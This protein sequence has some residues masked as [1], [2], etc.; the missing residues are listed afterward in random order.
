MGSNYEYVLLVHGN[1]W[2]SASG[3]TCK[4]PRICQQLIFASII[5][6]NTWKSNHL[7]SLSTDEARE[8]KQGV[9]V[10]CLAGISRSVT[11]TVA[12]LMHALQMELEPAY[13]LVKECKPNI[14]P[15][16]NFMVM[17]LDFQKSLGYD[18]LTL[19]PFLYAFCSRCPCKTMIHLNH[20]VVE[21]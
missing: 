15:N 21:V 20:Y 13:Q 8:K 2:D 9:L 14:S 16:I 1:L 3:A 19:F 10:H 5:C 4:Y 17:L 7:F 11:V 18:K 12:Y 6:L